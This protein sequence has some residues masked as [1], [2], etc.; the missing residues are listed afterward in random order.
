VNGNNKQLSAMTSSRSIHNEAVCI[1]GAQTDSGV[2]F[3][4]AFRCTVEQN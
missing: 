3:R 1:R 4:I 2:H